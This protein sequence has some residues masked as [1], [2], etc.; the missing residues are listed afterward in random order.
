MITRDIALVVGARPNFVKA[1]PVFQAL[2]RRHPQW[3]VR[4]IH[5]GQHYDDKLSDLFFRQLELPAPAV[6][7]NVGSASVTAQTARIMEKL[8]DELVHQRPD[9]VLVFGDVNSTLAAAL[10]VSKLNI[11]LAHVEAGLRS[12][13]RSMPEEVNRIVTDTLA[14]VLFVTEPSGEKNLLA[15]GVAME[16]IHFVGNTMIDTLLRLHGAAM[17]LDMPARLG[18]AP[19]GFAV[20][21]LHRP[22]NVDDP[23]A[24]REIMACLG[25]LAESVPVVFPLHPRTRA[26]LA[27]ASPAP[28]LPPHP[29]LRL[30]EPLGYLEFI[31]LMAAARLVITDSGGVQEETTILRVPCLT[32]RENTERPI[33]LTRGTNQLVGTDPR[34]MLLNANRVLAQ[35]WSMPEETPEK[36]DGKAAERLVD[37]LER[38]GPGA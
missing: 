37:V 6:N 8:E 38:I 21:T 35:A 11:P 13:D 3:S 33:T 32:L 18:L 24:L 25:E 16:R 30:I 36:W 14:E 12:F 19:A 23:A 29:R 5:T 26:R 34:H 31:G 20:V 1:A 2:R 4:L 17:A 7:L 15:E 27:Q 28:S 9:L 22:S 10:V